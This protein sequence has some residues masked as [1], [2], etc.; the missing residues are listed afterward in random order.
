MKNFLLPVLMA[1]STLLV[2]AQDDVPINPNFTWNGEI[3]LAANSVDPATLVTAW[4]KLTALNTVSIAVSRSADHGNTWSAPVYLPHFSSSYTSADPALIASS[5]GTFYFAYIDY[6]N[7]TLSEGGVYIT[8]ST[9]GITWS[10]PVLAIDAAAAPDIPI[11]RPWL[12]IDNSGGPFNGMLY[13]VTKSIK[14]A[15]STHHIYLVRS[16][17]DGLTWD[18]PK[19]LDDVLPVGGTA[20]TMGVPCVSAGGTLYVNYLS[21]DITQSLHVRDVFV[22]S[23]D[24]GQA[25]APGIISE[26]PFASAIP[27]EDS[28]YQYGYHI[29]ANPADNNNLVHVLTDRRD[30]DWDIWYNISQDGGDTWSATARL[31]DD[32]VGNGI[33]QDMCWGGFSPNGVYAALWRDR[34]DG[35][36]GQNS[37]YR[38]YGAYSADKGITF[39][40]NFALSS[41]PAAL[42]V[43]VNGNDF[44]GLALSDSAVYGTWADNRNGLNQEYFN[45]HALPAVSGIPREAASGR[46]QLIPSV[47]L[48]SSADLNPDYLKGNLSFRLCVYDLP[49]KC[50]LQQNNE[51]RIELGTLPRGMYVLAF[52]TSNNTVYQRFIIP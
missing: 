45:F 4:M 5:S 24:G 40:S 7:I 22:K 9:D 17:D 43:P 8:K 51:P 39:S 46:P 34:R 20:N 30:G 15:T 37:V 35:T 42:F 27:S 29:A 36:A 25:F 16:S 18:V 48:T 44:L 32:P 33:G 28:L 13:L 3:S 6:N 14:E 11:D 23:D 49:G 21:Y 31:N 47:I 12:A 26:L 19:I 10:A 52:I 38:I 50:L 1:F 2:N 41:T